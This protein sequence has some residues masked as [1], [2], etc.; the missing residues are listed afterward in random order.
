MNWDRLGV[1]QFQ[2]MQP[3][4]EPHSHCLQLS[5]LLLN[6]SL[7][8]DTRSL[9][10]ILVSLDASLIDISTTLLSGS[11]LKISQ[12]FLIAHKMISC[13]YTHLHCNSNDTLIINL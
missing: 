6:S 8:S 13:V 2:H 7:V 9:H 1:A 11:L 4:C 3:L 12:S 10:E 5:L